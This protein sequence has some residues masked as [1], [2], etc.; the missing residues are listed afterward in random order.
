MV[1][2]TSSHSTLEVCHIHFFYYNEICTISKSS[3][4][5]LQFMIHYKTLIQL[6]FS[7]CTV[8]PWVLG[9]LLFYCAFYCFF[10]FLIISLF[11]LFSLRPLL[12]WF[13][14]MVYVSYLESSAASYR[15]CLL[16]VSRCLVRIF[17]LVL[18]ML[19]KCCI[20]IFYNQL[21]SLMLLISF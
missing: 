20:G 5:T 11:F 21:L 6:S 8:T 19:H 3:S 17:S 10:V 7:S 16:L 1:V 9:L 12:S 15:A 13:P 2:V 14:S 4:S 18:C